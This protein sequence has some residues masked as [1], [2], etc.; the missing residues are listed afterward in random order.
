MAMNPLE[1][2]A[3]P[4]TK[5][6]LED[7]LG[8]GRY[9]RFDK[10]YNEIL[11]LHFDAK[12]QWSK[13]ENS[14]F[15][16]FYYRGKKP[17]FSIRWGIDYFYGYLILSSKDYIKITNHPK[18]TEYS[19]SVVRKFPENRAKRMVRIEANLEKM[20]EQEGFFDLIPAL[21]DVLL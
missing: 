8:L 20:N 1:Y 9:R 6:D 14:W 19:L 18:M 10:I 16:Q 3:M 17:L 5:E 21:I 13:N 11:S 2:N 7:Y 12:L 4:P 15:H